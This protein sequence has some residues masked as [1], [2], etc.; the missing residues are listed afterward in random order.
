MIIHIQQGIKDSKYDY[1]TTVELFEKMGYKI[2]D[3]GSYDKEKKLSEV[4]LIK[5]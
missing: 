4:V 1:L 2:F 3:I 5:D